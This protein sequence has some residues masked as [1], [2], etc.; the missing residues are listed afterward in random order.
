VDCLEETLEKSLQAK[1]SSNLRVSILLDYTR[2]SRGT[3]DDDLISSKAYF[4]VRLDKPFFREAVLTNW[5][6]LLKSYLLKT[7][8]VYTSNYLFPENLQAEQLFFQK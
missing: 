4:T 6:Y 5:T 7:G 3:Y 1:G 2:G 8:F